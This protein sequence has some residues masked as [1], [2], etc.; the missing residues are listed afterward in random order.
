QP[1]TL[2][3]LPIGD[4]MIHD[5]GK[6]QAPNRRP[7]A[8]VLFA[9]LLFISLFLVPATARPVNPRRTPV[10]EVVEKVRPAVVNIHSERNVKSGA[11]AEGYNTAPSPNRVNGMGTG[12]LI[13]PR[14]YIITNYHVVE[15]V[16]VIRVR[17][18]DGGSYQ[19]AVV[20]RDHEADLA[21]LEIDAGR[22]LP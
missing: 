15:D 17:L 3:P 7:C 22:P 16:S 9:F 5:P 12:V 19:A 11:S 1:P 18:S 6:S 8:V 14:G 10:V 20:A 13:D 21:L 4:V 2:Q